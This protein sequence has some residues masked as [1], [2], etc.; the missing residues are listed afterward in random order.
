[1]VLGIVDGLSGWD[2]QRA[3][4]PNKADVWKHLV[5]GRYCSN[6]SLQC[7]QT[8]CGNILFR[9]P[10]S[11]FKYCGC[12]VEKLTVQPHLAGSTSEYIFRTFSNGINLGRGGKTSEQNRPL[13]NK[14]LSVIV[15]G[16]LFVRWRNCHLIKFVH[17]EPRKYHLVFE[18]WRHVD[19]NCL[20]LKRLISR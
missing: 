13:P 16:A 11:L 2:I 8:A 9:N 14:S 6:W 20:P 17:L 15:F 19:R 1:M 3:C 4:V 10:T 7:K 5:T 12:F 18:R